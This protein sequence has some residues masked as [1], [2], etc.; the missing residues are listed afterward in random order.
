MELSKNM[1]I[2][3]KPVE[4]EGRSFDVYNPATGDVLGQ[5]DGAS[6]KQ[7]ELA[8]AAAR[9]AFNDWRLQSLESRSQLLLKVAEVIGAHEQELAHLLVLEQ[10]K[11]LQ[12]AKNEIK[13]A[14]AFT[15]F[16]ASL[17][18]PREVVL[19]TP[20]K[21]IEV[22]R[23]PL[24]VVASITPWNYPLMIL[25]WHTMPALMSGNTVVCKPSENTPFSTIKLLGYIASVLPDGVINLVT[26]A[27]DVG[28]LLSGHPD[29]N[30]VV[31]TGSI[32]TGKAIMRSSAETLKKLTLELGGN[33][34]GIVLPNTDIEP[35]VD[36]IFTAA[37]KNQGQTCAALKRL[38]VHESQIDDLAARLAERAKKEVVGN[39]LDEA[40]T[41]GPVQNR[42]Q[43]ELIKSLLDDIKATGGTLLSGGEALNDKGYFVAPTI[44]N[45]A[46]KDSRIVRIEQFGPILPIIAYN[47]I[48]EAI[49]EANSGEEGLGG[50]V[51]GNDQSLAIQIANQLDTGSTWINNH[52]ELNPL[53][54]FGGCKMSGIGSEF[55]KNA[56]LDYTSV[57]SMH[58]TK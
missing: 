37:F 49:Q 32:G 26:G 21:Q 16:F 31:F 19:T 8:V 38:Y 29:V 15:R 17:T 12:D 20:E 13:G 22:L 6:S 57:H 54:P 7:V 33:D 41:F 46:P 14:V 45:R 10:G 44:V 23:K 56:L 18:L 52:G 58:I 36:R 43:F 30:K 1:I 42:A 25:I 48:D 55:G 39:G 50:S 27:G 35:Y 34:A 5:C 9:L 53:A 51:W 2:N 47:E 3:G 11:P 28:A 4:A 40:T 24:G